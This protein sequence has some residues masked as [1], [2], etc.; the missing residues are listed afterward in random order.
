MRKDVVDT[1]GVQVEALAEVTGAHRRTL[2]VPAG[3]SRA[4][5]R[6]PHQRPIRF[7]A[8]PEREIGGIAF[9]R[10]ELRSNALPERLANVPGE[11]SGAGGTP[12]R[13][14][15]PGGDPIRRLT[16]EQP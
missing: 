1:A 14:G 12:H 2:D 5:G 10:G 3:K 15:Q 6:I 8:L 13:P 7:G 4:P 16:R 9:S 11:P